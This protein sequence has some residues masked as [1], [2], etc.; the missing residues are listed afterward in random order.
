MEILQEFDHTGPVVSSPLDPYSKLTAKDGPLLPNP[1]IYRHLGGKLNYLTHTRPDL[2]F[3]VLK[4]IQSMQ[5]KP[6]QSHYSTALRVLRYP[7]IDPSQ[8]IIL[9]SDPSL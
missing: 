4:L 5:K 6:T 1:T 9:S 8:G 2:S 3:V 7:S